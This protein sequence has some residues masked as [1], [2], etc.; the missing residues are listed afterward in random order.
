MAENVLWVL[1]QRPQGGRLLILAHNAH[2]FA[3]TGSVTLGPLRPRAPTLLGKR[4][5]AALGGRY[6]VIGTDARALGYY[7]E[8]QDPVNRESLGSALAELGHSWLL[9]DLDAAAKDP[10]V[11]AWLRE[12]RLV[13]FQ[14]GY[15][16]IRPA[17]AADVLIYADSLSPTGGEIP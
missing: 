4:L 15:Q 2:V 10:A 1:R 7:V 17:I 9:L 5:R 8:E 16:R 6:L 14:W 3:D 12:P 13:R 11:E